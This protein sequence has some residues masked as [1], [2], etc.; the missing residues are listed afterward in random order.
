MKIL[1]I[2][3]SFYLVFKGNDPAKALCV[4]LPGSCPQ[5]LSIAQY[6]V[7]VGPGKGTKLGFGQIGEMEE[8][9]SRSLCDRGRDVLIMPSI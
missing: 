6:K 2:E 7:K 3:K 9:L 4:L 5:H 8:C 1:I